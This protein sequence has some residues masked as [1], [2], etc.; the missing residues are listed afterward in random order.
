MKIHEYQ[1]KELFNKYGIPIPKGG[2][3]FNIEEAQQQV[4]LG[5]QMRKTLQEQVDTLISLQVNFIPE[6][7][8][9][10]ID[11]K[12]NARTIPVSNSSPQ[13]LYRPS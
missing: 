6:I 13:K 1:A 7:F 11:T 9:S 12:T 8:K 10:G 3:A 2:V 5:R 4:G